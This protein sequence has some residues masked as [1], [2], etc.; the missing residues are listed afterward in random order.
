MCTTG[1]TSDNRWADRGREGIAPG[2]IFPA[3]MA[4]SWCYMMLSFA[5]KH[6]E[7]LLLPYF[8]ASSL[9]EASKSQ[10]QISILSSFPFQAMQL[11][12]IIHFVVVFAL[13]YF[14]QLCMRIMTREGNEASFSAF[15]D[16]RFYQ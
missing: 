13:L 6:G 15:H 5:Q 9:L 11:L 4:C 10:T 14:F 1:G 2:N 12:P 16:F 3:N 7:Y 8:C